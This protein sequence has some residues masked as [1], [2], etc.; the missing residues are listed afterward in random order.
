[1]SREALLGIRVTSLFSVIESSAA[2]MTKLLDN[3]LREQLQTVD[4][5]MHEPVSACGFT[6]LKLGESRF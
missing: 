4:L 1:M 6:L 2:P 3:F 5:G